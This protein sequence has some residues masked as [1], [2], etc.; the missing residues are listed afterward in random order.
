M[1]ASSVEIRLL[2]LDRI[3]KSREWMV[4]TEKLVGLLTGVLGI[5][6]VGWL[7]H[8]VSMIER[9]RIVGSAGFDDGVDAVMG[10]ISTTDLVSV[11]SPA[12]FEIAA[13]NVIVV[14]VM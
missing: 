12:E 8:T 5:G 2:F 4:L 13:F 6:V 3:S 14:I 1:V 11:L 7:M 10:I 9:V